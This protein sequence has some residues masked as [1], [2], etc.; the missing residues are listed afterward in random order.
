MNAVRI[1]WCVAAAALLCL[2]I[3]ES[4][5][6]GWVAAGVIVV[7]AL[8]PDMPILR[9]FQSNGIMRVQYVRLYNVLHSTWIPLALMLSAMFPVPSLGWGLRPG[10]E[11]FLAGVAWLLHIS[12]DRAAGFG[13][14]QSDGTIRP[15]GTRGH[16][17]ARA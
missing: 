6:Y 2:A 17:E 1:A 4:V 13:M 11:L 3:F 16:S 5:K 9:G 12:I 8:L 15:V 14:R 10:L 7:F